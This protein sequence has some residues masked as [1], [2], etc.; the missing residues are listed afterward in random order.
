MRGEFQLC[1][2][3]NVVNLS[4]YIKSNKKPMAC[5]KWGCGGDMNIFVA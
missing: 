2:T 3:E 5:F 1:G 4:L